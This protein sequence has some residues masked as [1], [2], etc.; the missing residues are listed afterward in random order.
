M[1]PQIESA[2]CNLEECEYLILPRVSDFIGHRIESLYFEPHIIVFSILLRRNYGG[3]L[4]TDPA[5]GYR[6][7]SSRI[8]LQV[9]CK[10][11]VNISPR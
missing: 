2:F 11:C 8:S 9:A 1:G 5:A 10:I 4:Q 3:M 6:T 7:A